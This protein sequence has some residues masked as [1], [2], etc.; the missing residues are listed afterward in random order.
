MK[1][2]PVNRTWRNGDGLE[3]PFGT[4]FSKFHQVQ[5]LAHKAKACRR[6]HLVS[7]RPCACLSFLMSYTS[8]YRTFGSKYAK[9]KALLCKNLGLSFSDI[10]FFLD[11][12]SLTGNLYVEPV[13]TQPTNTFQRQ[14]IATLSTLFVMY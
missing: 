1:L 2:R 9:F 7:Y 5:I 12:Y 3:I 11:R 8:F 13:F 6:L 4:H 10:F 14:L